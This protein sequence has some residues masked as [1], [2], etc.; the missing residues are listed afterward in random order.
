MSLPKQ[1][2]YPGVPMSD[3][4]KWD[5]ANYST[6]KH[7][8]RS[9]AH[10]MQR[11][12]HP[13]EPT[14]AMDLGQATHTAILEPER[15]ERDYVVGPKVDRRFKKDKEIW[16][17][18]LEQNPDKEILKTQDYARCIAMGEAVR[19]NSVMRELL[20]G[21]GGNELSFVWRDTDTDV[22][23][24]GRI[25]HFGRLWGNAAIADVK[26]TMDASPRGWAR[27]VARYQYHVQ[28]A[29]YLDALDTIEPVVERKFL[30]LALESEPPYAV[31]LYEPDFEAIEQ[32]RKSYKHWL[33]LWAECRRSG[34]WPGYEMAIQSL[35]LPRWAVDWEE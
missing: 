8:K 11:Y 20:D 18:F 26:T 16:A 21:I 32:G 2:I 10:A 9:C 25:D 28:A 31:G 6:L 15:F 19:R 5:A 33:E 35:M 13:P 34:T 22:W 4:G 14:P 3:Y 27:E 24:K 17:R 7:F 12:M 30:W 1:G 29:M 23:C